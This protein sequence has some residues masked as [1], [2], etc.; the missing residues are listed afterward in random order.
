MAPCPMS[1]WTGEHRRTPDGGV[2]SVYRPCTAE[3]TMRR[4]DEITSGGVTAWSARFMC[5]ECWE[6]GEGRCGYWRPIGTPEDWNDD[7]Q[8]L[9]VNVEQTLAA[10]LGAIDRMAHRDG[11]ERRRA[12]RH[13]RR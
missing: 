3:A 1:V 12:G 2:R 4:L 9:R 10:F 11:F 13:V 6:T 8:V 5:T 7:S